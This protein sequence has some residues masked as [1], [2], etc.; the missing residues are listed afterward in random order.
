MS[1][2]YN[3]ETETFM[4]VPRNKIDWYPRIDYEKCDYCMDCVEFC[5]HDVFE[6]REE[7]EKKLIV[8]NPNNCVVFC[9]AC[10]KACSPD[11]LNF[12]EKSEV[13]EHIKN[14]RNNQ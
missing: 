2:E 10:S 9:R 3:S 11:A 6:V 1:K 5:P 14:L 4:G 13:K 7:E 12:P 8:K